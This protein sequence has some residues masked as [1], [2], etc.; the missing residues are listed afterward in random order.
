[1]DIEDDNELMDEQNKVK[2]AAE[3]N[4]V[5]V[6]SEEMLANGEQRMKK[7]QKGDALDKYMDHDKVSNTKMNIERKYSIDKGMDAETIKKMES[8]A[9][10]EQYK[11][12]KDLNKL[13]ERASPKMIAK[14]RQS[15]MLEEEQKK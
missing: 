10:K 7:A 11:A 14:R 12:M 15:L 9:Q 13:N 1:M 6:M 4:M 8:A 5:K 2:L 3:I